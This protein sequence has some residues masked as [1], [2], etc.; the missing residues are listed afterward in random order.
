MIKLNHS[1]F[2]RKKKYFN[3]NIEI[4][5]NFS[6]NFLWKLFLKL[7]YKVYLYSF[8]NLLII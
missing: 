1:K 3:N 5:F 4:I 6:L 8:N 2:F 7:K